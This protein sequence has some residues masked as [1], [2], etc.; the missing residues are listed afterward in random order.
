MNLIPKDI[1]G[2]THGLRQRRMCGAVLQSGSIVEEGSHRELVGR[3]GGAYATL[4]SLQLAAQHAAGPAQQAFE[5]IAAADDIVVLP[6]ANQAC[7]T[8]PL[9]HLAHATH[10]HGP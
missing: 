8:H 7:A 3:S 4:L 9:S 1:F 2:P 6:A 5:E 10:T